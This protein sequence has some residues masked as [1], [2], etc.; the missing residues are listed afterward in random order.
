[1]ISHVNI[2]LGDFPRCTTPALGV[3][4]THTLQC[5]LQGQ[6]ASQLFWNNQPLFKGPLLPQSAFS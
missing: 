4:H 5:T 6:G 3:D 2:V 1:M